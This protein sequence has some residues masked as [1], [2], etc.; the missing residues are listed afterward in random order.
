MSIAIHPRHF[1]VEKAYLDIDN[2][3]TEAI[4]KNPDLT[5]MELMFIL[6]RLAASWIKYGI[7]D[8]RKEEE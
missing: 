3:V 1:P 8:E 7:H 5:Y 6:N 4:G 2:A